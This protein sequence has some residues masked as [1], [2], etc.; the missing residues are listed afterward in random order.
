MVRPSFPG[1]QI[2]WSRLGLRPCKSGIFL[3]KW[4]KKLQAEAKNNGYGSPS[5][6]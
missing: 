5:D 2:K 3:C 4:H 6:R 1:F